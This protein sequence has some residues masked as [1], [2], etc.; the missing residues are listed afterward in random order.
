MRTAVPREAVDIY[1]NALA[2]STRGDYSKALSEY[3]KAIELY[4]R[5]IEAYNNIGEIYSRIGDREHAISTYMRALS[6]ERNHKIL[7]NI[8]VEYYNRHDYQQ[9]LKYFRESL[10]SEPGFLEGNF[11]L[12]M[13]LFNLKEL[14]LAEGAFARVV[15]IDRRHLKA[16]YMLSYIYYE[17]KEYA[18]TIECLDRIRDI[19]DDR[20]FVNKYYGF[21]HFHMGNFDKAIEYLT[22]ALESNPRYARFRNYL[23]ELTYENKLK[24]IG[25]L[26]GRVREMEAKLLRSTPSIRELSHLSMLYIFKGEYKKAENLLLSARP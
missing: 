17:W 5:F 23:R 7:L 21:C 20:Q 6:I 14:R 25:D 9:A 10:A 11:Y 3:S 19:A 18:K 8:G 26:D 1:N 22:V 2:L 16:N 12:G 13:T 4:P 24:E 15:S